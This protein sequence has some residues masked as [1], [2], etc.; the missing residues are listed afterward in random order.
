[1]KIVLF[2]DSITDMERNRDVNAQVGEYG[3]GYPFFVAGELLSEN[4]KWYKIYNRGISGDRTVDLYARIKRDVWNIEPDVLSI[5][6]GINDIWHD[7]TEDVDSANGVDIERFEKVYRMVIEDTLKRLPNLK[8]MLI[9]PFVL[10]GVATEMRYD[11]FLK[12]KEYAKVVK[13]LAEEYN[14]NFVPLQ[15]R[16][17]LAAEKFGAEKYLY[18]G[19]HPTVAGAKL[20]ADE[21]LKAF[22]SM[23]EKR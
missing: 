5:L 9:E 22:G 14:L 19:V 7:L 16:F 23:V 10:K 21:W 3:F 11:E 12:V 17:D 15:E 2:G 4:P 18:D 20:I 13:R 6:I 8:I 1:M